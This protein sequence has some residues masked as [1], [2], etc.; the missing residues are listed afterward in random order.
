MKKYLFLIPTLFVM[1]LNCL[2]FGQ[3]AAADASIDYS[4]YIKEPEE[5]TIYYDCCDVE[6][7]KPYVIERLSS[8][9]DFQ[10]LSKAF[11]EDFLSFKDYFYSVDVSE[12]SYEDFHSGKSDLIVSMFFTEIKNTDAFYEDD[13]YA[14]YK[15]M[16]TVSFNFRVSQDNT[17]SDVTFS[18][19]RTYWYENIGFYYDKISGNFLPFEYSGG[20]P[21]P[22]PFHYNIQSSLDTPSYHF[23]MDTTIPDFD[24][25]YGLSPDKSLP[26]LTVIFLPALSGEVD[27][28]ISREDGISS[29]VSNMKMTVINNSSFPVQYK[30]YI[31]KKNQITHRHEVNIGS[32][33]KFINSNPF[34]GTSFDD[35]PVFV[36]Y[37][38]EWV[39]SSSLDSSAT[40]LNQV[41]EKQN[42]AT[43]WHYL[44]AK[45][46]V[47]VTFN[48]SQINLIEKEEY[49]VYVDAV[50][51]DY[52]CSSLI[53]QSAVEDIY[54]ELKQLSQGDVV[55]VHQSTFSMVH[56]SDV[57]YDPADSSNG[58]L[59]YSSY[60]DGYT[61]SFSYNAREKDDGTVDYTKK[62]VS[63]SASKGSTWGNV[64]SGSIPSG[65]SS[66]SSSASFL[67]LSNSFSNFFRFVNQVFNYFPLSITSV[68]AVGVTS[69][70]VLGIVKAV[71][72]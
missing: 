60:D 41:P 15:G 66:N 70:V 43:E 61:Y 52:G 38:N 48:F 39:Y 47:D 5:I 24:Y 13:E 55:T 69:I 63:S 19:S 2:V 40:W 68:Y 37:S 53:F 49:I 62:D 36:Y 3:V 17:V 59:P 44:S 46:S 16:Y 9:S 35:D 22:P 11:G 10:R 12:T 50:R 30:M 58:V 1:L 26:N 8:C 23:Y 34:S 6:F 72:K 56:Y 25:P 71:F 4:Q 67:S 42:K 20:P 57:K 45:D 54:P 33:D 32:P 29:L 18:A 14:I 28:N 27:R 21:S 64:S 31:M 51:C 65:S 7:I